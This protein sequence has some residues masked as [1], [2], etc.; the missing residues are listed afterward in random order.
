[1]R[2]GRIGLIRV[3]HIDERHYCNL[4]RGNWGLAAGFPDRFIYPDFAISFVLEST[5]HSRVVEALNVIKFV[6]SSSCSC[7]EIASIDCLS[8]WYPEESFN[9]RVVGAGAD[10]PHAAGYVVAFENSLILV[11]GELTAAIGMHYQ[12]LPVLVLPE[13]D[14][15]SLKDQPAIPGRT[16]W[17]TN[18]QP[19]AQVDDNAKIQPVLG[20]P[21][22]SDI[23]CPL[24]VRL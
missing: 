16:H 12:R 13:R 24:G 17:P 6:G 18:D 7:S 3:A 4:V 23:G 9:E 21:H 5:E 10:A 1:M 14:K 20:R 11:A 19:M 8:L 2:S 22:V 15:H